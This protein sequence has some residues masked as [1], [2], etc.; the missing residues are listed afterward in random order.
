MRAES[1]F[2][3]YINCDI[4]IMTLELCTL[5]GLINDKLMSINLSDDGKE[6]EEISPSSFEDAI[7]YNLEL[8][9]LEQKWNFFSW[10]EFNS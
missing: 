10:T 2:K 6:C 9:W 8:T 1:I 4:D 7:D 3:E 5:G